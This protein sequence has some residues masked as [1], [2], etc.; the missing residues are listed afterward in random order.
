MSFMDTQALE[1]T[2]AKARLGITAQLP[3]IAADCWF[4][5]NV[6][7]LVDLQP[8]YE[9][10]SV[11]AHWSNERARIFL[12]LEASDSVPDPSCAGIFPWV[13]QQSWL[14]LLHKPPI[15]SATE[16]ASLAREQLSGRGSAALA[17]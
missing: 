4:P 7:R 14:L 8:A 15:V 12:L 16:I 13:Q 17:N 10:W 9:P 1:V 11:T 5:G 2:M 6:Q 3:Q